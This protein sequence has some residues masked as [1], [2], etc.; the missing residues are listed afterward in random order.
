MNKFKLILS[1]AFI[2]ALV[3]TCSDEQII[4]AENAAINRSQEVTGNGGPSG[5]H[6]N[7][8]II[9]V[10]RDKEADMTGNNGRRIFVKL[11][12]QSKIKL[13]EGDEFAVLD[14]NGTDNDGA[15]FQL[16]NPDPDGDGESSYS[17][18]M[19]ALGG[20]GGNATITTC[21]DADVDDITSDGYYEVC[22][23]DPLVVESSNGNGPPKFENVSRKL[24]TVYVEYDICVDED[25]EEGCEIFI[26]AG[27][28]TIFDE[29]FEDYFWKYDNDGLKLLQL[30]FYEIPTNID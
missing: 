15:K 12:G 2:I 14:A 22:S 11:N 29:I 21:A 27:R 7:L 20:P 5:P 18:Y 3:F 9:G 30:R 10:P 19:R 23:A 24:L 25:G 17:V 16:P 13:A 8:N 1:G 26:P 4:E 6:Y 28:Y